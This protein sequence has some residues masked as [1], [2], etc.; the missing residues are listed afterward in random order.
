MLRLAAPY[1]VL[2]AVVLVVYA[3]PLFT[4]RV[5][6]YRDLGIT[7]PI[8]AEARIGG[9][10]DT[11]LPLWTHAVSNGRP[12]LANPSYALLAPFNVLYWVL[13][14]APAFNLFLVL[15]VALA[16]CAMICLARRLGCSGPAAFTAGAAY[17]LGGGL[18]SA[19]TLYWTVVAAAW[20][21]F[22][23]AAAVV[24][25]R[26]ATPRHVALVAIAMAMQA[27]G[28]QPEPIAATILVG[29]AASW[30]CAAGSIGRRA[31]LVLVTWAAGILGGLA[32]AAPQLL[33]SALHARTTLRALGFTTAGLLYNSLH[34]LRALWLFVP[35]LGGNPVEAREPGGFPGA[36]WLDGR[37]PYLLSIYL[38]IVAVALAV[39][40]VALTRQGS[41]SRSLVRTLAGLALLA[42][43]LAMGRHL[44]GVAALLEALPFPIPFRY[45]EKV[46]YV[47]FLAIP[48]LAAFGIDA[49]GA[50]RVPRLGVL[51]AAAAV[52]DL[53]IA[54]RGYT[55]TIE[56]AALAATPLARELAD[57][58][59]ALGI[60]EGAWRMHHER[61]RSSGGW[62][63]PAG[64]IPP[65]EEDFFRWQVGM[66]VPPTAAPHHAHAAMEIEGDL[67]DDARYFAMI[68]A[69]Y[70][71]PPQ[72]L[73][74]AL[75]EAGV[76]WVVSP[77]PDLEA[78][79]GGLLVPELSLGAS[80]GVPPG[81]GRVY[82]NRC[83]LPRARLVTEVS[84]ISTPSLG[85]LPPMAQ[86]RY[87]RSAPWPPPVVVEAE[88]DPAFPVLGGTGEAGAVTGSPRTTGG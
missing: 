36:A 43:V 47:T 45:P 67:L 6:F 17:A 48:P 70:N 29:V 66:L 80:E 55:P 68:R 74:R 81:S 44:P 56:S 5:F 9:E 41:P 59:R 63:P 51:L 11:I 3:D 77:K 38:G 1:L 71:G 58:S 14:F 73:P 31:R 7:G 72:A 69:A 15:H 64:S 35:G 85:Q 46:L 33:P 53:V 83:F 88:G 82:R 22:V 57:R 32:L 40:A 78:K 4:G 60:P 62:G 10:R 13:P 84:R 8:L 24:A 20:A 23:I 49:L 30:M 39:A 2:V 54:H 21:P 75:G 87:E 28:G 76:L 79:T 52:L 86:R 50:S 61:Q 12:L 26:T 37:T 34:P 18:V 19:L 42:V 25:V 65:T 16:G 27:F